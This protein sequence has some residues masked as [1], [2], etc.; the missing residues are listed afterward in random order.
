LLDAV[1]TE[2]LRVDAETTANQYQQPGED[3]TAAEWMFFNQKFVGS[4]TGIG[5][6]S[7]EYVLESI[8]SRI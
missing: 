4:N 7:Y 1:T 2:A 3:E 6:A 5:S 8:R